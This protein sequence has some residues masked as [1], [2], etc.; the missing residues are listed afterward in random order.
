[1][2]LDSGIGVPI[3]VSDK[4]LYN[5]VLVIEMREYKVRSMDFLSSHLA[6]I[7]SY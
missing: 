5:N 2:S 1:M 6:R 7:D 3:R 4:I